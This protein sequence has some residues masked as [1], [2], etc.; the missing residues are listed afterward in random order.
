M[1]LIFIYLC[2]SLKLKTLNGKGEERRRK[3]GDGRGGGGGGRRRCRKRWEPKF[4]ILL[5]NF[6]SLALYFL[7]FRFRF[8][9]RAPRHTPFFRD[10]LLLIF[11]YCRSSSKDLEKKRGCGVLKGVSKE[12][13]KGRETHSSLAS[14][15]F[16]IDKAPRIC[17]PP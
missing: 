15:S 7:S 17:F 11:L 12:E 5:S 1:A 4:V 16:F 3:R 9:V 10:D 13:E 8:F 14:R 6:S 2:Q